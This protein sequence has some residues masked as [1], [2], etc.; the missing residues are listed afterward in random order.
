M[1]SPFASTVTARV[2]AAL[3]WS[4]PR[5][6]FG[7]LVELCLGRFRFG[8]LKGGGNHGLAASIGQVE[9]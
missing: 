1:V 2:P 8:H 6:S 5:A 9:R 7:E 3:I 4:A